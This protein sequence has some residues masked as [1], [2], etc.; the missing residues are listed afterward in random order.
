MV[1]RWTRDRM[2]WAM[3]SGSPGNN[4]WWSGSDRSVVFWRFVGVEETVMAVFG[5]GAWAISS[6]GREMERD[7]IGAF[8]EFF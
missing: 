6:I 5:M 1:V 7:D 4:G 8:Q 3:W 2:S